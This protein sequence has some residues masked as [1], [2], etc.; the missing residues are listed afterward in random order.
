MIICEIIKICGC[1]NKFLNVSDNI[2]I[3]RI[4]IFNQNFNIKCVDLIG[5]RNI[6][7]HFVLRFLI[8]LYW[9]LELVHHLFSIGQKNLLRFVKAGR[10]CKII[11]IHRKTMSLWLEGLMKRNQGY[12]I[13]KTAFYCRIYQSTANSSRK[14]IK[15]TRSEQKKHQER[16]SERI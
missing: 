11:N 5:F 10:G 9:G 16:V 12:Q 6:R 2:K 13:I 14:Y 8:K 7:M 3:I 15:S 1:Q 4:E